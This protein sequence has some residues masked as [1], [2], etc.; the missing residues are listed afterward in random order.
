MRQFSRRKGVLFHDT[1]LV[2]LDYAVP[3][4]VKKFLQYFQDMIKVNSLLAVCQSFIVKISTL[5]K[6]FDK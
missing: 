3:E 4:P 5:L 6:S 2:R 1:T